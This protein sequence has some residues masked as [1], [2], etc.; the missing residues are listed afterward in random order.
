MKNN[1]FVRI[2]KD[3]LRIFSENEMSVYSG[4]ATL[5][6]LMAMIPL[7]MLVIAIIN[8]MPGF[9]AADFSAWIS[10]F[11]K[12]LPSVQSM[13]DGVIRNLNAQSGGLIA[14]VSAVTTLWSASNGVSAIQTGLEQISGQP[15]SGLKGKPKALLFTILFILLVPALLVSQ[16][17]KQ[18]LIDLIDSLMAALP[19]ETLPPLLKKILESS[20]PVALAAMIALFVLCYAWLPAGKKPD[21]KAQ[22]PGALFTSIAT[23]VFTLAFGFFMGNFWK[24]SSIYG[25]LAAIFLVAM[26][27]KFVITILF[28]GA[29]LNKALENNKN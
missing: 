21:F 4:Y 26:W 19:L 14:S 20:G 27:L 7:L 15:K 6:I 24:A 25:S 8:V 22:L 5:Y 29:S 11:L 13:L 9:S 16:L 12:D 2:I 23:A 18:P 17:L 28:Y 3:T 1:R 10:Q